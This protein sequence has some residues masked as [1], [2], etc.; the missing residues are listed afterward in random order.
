[1]AEQ[2]CGNCKFK[3]SGECHEAPPQLFVNP[4]TANIQQIDSMKGSW[5]KVENKDWCGK[6][7]AEAT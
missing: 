6:W 5:P 1:M 4:T 3:K 2:K 7:E